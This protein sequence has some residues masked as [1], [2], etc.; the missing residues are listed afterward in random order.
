MSEPLQPSGHPAPADLLLHLEEPSEPIRTHIAGCAACQSLLAALQE[1]ESN[2]AEWRNIQS[3]L[4]PPP[5]PVTALQARMRAEAAPLSWWRRNRTIARWTPA[6]ALAGAAA[7]LVLIFSTNG[8]WNPVAVEAA[9]ILRH[10]SEQVQQTRS[11]KTPAA[12]RHYRIRQGGRELPSI[13]DA[14]LQ[15]ARIDRRD[16][17]NPDDYARWRSEQ[18]EKQDTITRG[19]GWVRLSTAV[20]GNRAIESASITVDSHDWH[21]L[22]RSVHFRGEDEIQM[23]AAPA[24]AEV[25]SQGAPDGSKPDESGALKPPAPTETTAPAATSEIAMWEVLHA[26]GADIHSAAQL[27]RQDGAVCYELWSDPSD[28]E[29][30]TRAMQAIRGAKPCSQSK[31]PEREKLLEPISAGTTAE[32]PS[33]ALLTARFGDKDRAG[34]YLDDVTRQYVVLLARVTALD[35]YLRWFPPTRMETL[36]MPSRRRVE[37]I[38]LSDAAAVTTEANQYLRLIGEGLAALAARPASA[39][40]VGP[41]SAALHCTSI[42]SASTLLEDLRSL[43]REFATLFGSGSE[44]AS[45]VERT[46]RTRDAFE[47]RLA[48][49]CAK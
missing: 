44:L 13:D 35:R 34:Q 3:A 41:A 23:E 16:P 48:A 49:L 18:T 5:P 42:E 30:V 10:A 39:A 31:S 21:P 9:E 7:C 11:A 19:N 40:P 15:L 37:A 28:R 46:A 8:I 22:I 45:S 47:H 27:R 43:H 14:K 32:S 25:T 20:L 17:L 4:A 36:D 38:A 12:P 1:G 24:E 6:I 33:L 26:A 29:K 2:L